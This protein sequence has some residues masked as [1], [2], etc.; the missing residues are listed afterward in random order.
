MNTD[1][2]TELKFEDAI[3]WLADQAEQQGRWREKWFTYNK[4]GK[5]SLRGLEFSAI[6]S[7]RDIPNI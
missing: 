5:I 1:N 2:K 6:R 7:V 3:E 4:P